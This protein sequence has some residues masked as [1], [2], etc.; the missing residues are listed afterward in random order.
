MYG[1]QRL[2]ETTMSS[3]KDKETRVIMWRYL[4]LIIERALS[5]SSTVISSMLIFITSYYVNGRLSVSNV[6]ATLQL[7]ML[8]RFNVMFFSQSGIDHYY[9]LKEI[10]SRYL[11][12][13]ELPE[14]KM[15]NER[16]EEAQPISPD[17]RFVATL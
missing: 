17:S 3:L 13:L 10:F 4:F 2:Y 9:E 15:I 8:M 6:F 1:W 11:Q 7:F 5:L 16:G 14:T 12:I